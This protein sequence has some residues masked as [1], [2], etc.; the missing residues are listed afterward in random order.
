MPIRPYTTIFIDLDARNMIN[1]RHDAMP[2]LKTQNSPLRPSRRD[3]ETQNSKLK[4]QNSP[5]PPGRHH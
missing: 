1:G 4:T 3:S 2:K 5:L